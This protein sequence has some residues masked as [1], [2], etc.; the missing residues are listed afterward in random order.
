L[1]VRIVR[2]A[3]IPLA[4][5]L[6]CCSGTSDDMHILAGACTFGEETR[7][8]D[9]DGPTLD[10]LAVAPLDDGAY[11]AWSERSGLFGI[12]LDA[13]GRAHGDRVRLGPPCSG[14]LDALRDGERVL[15]ACSVRGDPERGDRGAIVVYARDGD[16]VRVLERH[17]GVGAEGSGVALARS[18]SGVAVGWQEAQGATSAAW[19]TDLGGTAEPRRLSR[20]GFRATAPALVF[21]DDTLLALWGELWIDAEGDSAGRIQLQAGHR[22]PRSIGDLAYEQML[23]VLTP[24]ETEGA[25]GA[26]LAFRDRRPAGTRPN[27]LLSRIEASTREVT[28]IRGAPANA[29][30]ASVAVPCENAVMVVA[31]RTHSRTE[32]LVSVRRHTTALDGMG[33]EQQL[34]EHAATFEWA[35]AVC[36]GERLL[37]VYGARSSPATPVGSVRATTVDCEASP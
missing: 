10:G 37:V 1:S 20:G 9:L 24:D 32:R 3:F 2:I 35:D 36:L 8:F 19:V 29:A 28:A 12:A 14:G 33:P 16:S 27:V 18:G 23:P 13:M 31:P 26:I 4:A 15:I 21:E 25:G 6:A 34:Y 5:A 22:A 7:L 30:G 11:F 17:E